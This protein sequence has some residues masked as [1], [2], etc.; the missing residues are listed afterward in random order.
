MR[1]HTHNASQGTSLVVL[2]VDVASAPQQYFTRRS[3]T[4]GCGE[5]ERGPVAVEVALILN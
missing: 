4:I 3:M 5:D 1:H 2:R